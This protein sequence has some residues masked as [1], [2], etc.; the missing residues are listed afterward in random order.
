MSI[1]K[2][3]E[4]IGNLCLENTISRRKTN[5][6]VGFIFSFVSWVIEN[7]INMLQ[8]KRLKC[9]NKQSQQTNIQLTHKEYVEYTNHVDK[10]KEILF[11]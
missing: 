8:K 5:I 6:T 10:L 4:R 3:K 1:T 7:D 9:K 11:G 2:F